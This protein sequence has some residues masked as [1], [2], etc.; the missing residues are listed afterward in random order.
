VTIKKGKL[1]TANCCSSRGGGSFRLT[2]ALNIPQLYNTIMTI[3]HFV[4]RRL[5]WQRGRFA[6]FLTA[7]RSKRGIMLLLSLSVRHS[8]DT[9]LETVQDIKILSAPYDRE[10]CF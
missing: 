7:Q 5:Q 2:P 10:G 6:E 1:T 4:L 8:W 3:R 9:P